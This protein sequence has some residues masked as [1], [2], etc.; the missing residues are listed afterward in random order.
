MDKLLTP[1]EIADI[2]K[3]KKTTVYEMLKRNEIPS[4]R[5]GKQIRVREKDFQDYLKQTSCD[6][7]LTE[8]I[9]DAV[10]ETQALHTT[11]PLPE[12]PSFLRSES[13]ILKQDYLKN[14]TGLIISG[15]NAA[16]DL[17]CAHIESEPEGLPVMRSSQNSYNSLYALYFQ[18]IHAA[19]IALWSETFGQCNTP[20]IS[21]M[22]PGVP[23]VRIHLAQ[24]TYGLYCLKETAP[25]IQSVSDLAASGM[26]I[27]NREKGSTSRILLDELLMSAQILPEQMPGYKKEVLSDL[28]CATA[29]A[30]GK[31][32]AAVGS[33]TVLPQFQALTMIP[34]K[35]IDAELVFEKQYLKHPAFQAMIRIIQSDYFKNELSHLPG[36]NVLRTGEIIM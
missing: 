16:M 34:L 22:L 19:C 31:A 11:S 2:L 26:P 27:I 3:V 9:R 1:Q 14:L 10:P 20:F 12:V 21:Q 36:Y 28:A 13:S 6:T 35:T 18:K 24:M 32:A 33:S 29:I 15:Q 30:T 23:I 4:S 5:F 7:A 25:R 8:N 17:L